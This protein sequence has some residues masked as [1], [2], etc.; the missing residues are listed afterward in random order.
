MSEPAEI[1][2]EI[3][4]RGG[5]VA[6]TPPAADMRYN[7]DTVT[8]VFVRVEYRDGRI[9]EY[10]AREPQDFQMN[11]PESMSS[12]VFSPAGFAISVGG[13]FKA[14]TMGSPSLRMSFTANPRHDMDI[15]TEAT[16]PDDFEGIRY[17]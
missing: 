17:R 1:T 7:D 10:Q 6:E 9:R 11:Q 3:V 13:L 14:P 15:R 16:A 4:K 5:E 12:M 8:R 2:G